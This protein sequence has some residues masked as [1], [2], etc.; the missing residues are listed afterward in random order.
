MGNEKFVKQIDLFTKTVLD[1]IEK[2]RKRLAIE[3]FKRIIMR[4]PVDTGRARGNWQAT[5]GGPA[6]RTFELTDKGGEN[7]VTK[8]ANK[9]NASKLKTHPTIYL[10]NNIPYILRLENGG[11]NGPTAKVTDDG[12]SRQAPSGMVKVTLAEFPYI[13][14]QVARG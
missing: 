10:T 13:V 14:K 5:F 11:Y 4:T 12:Y 6:T 7:T 2:F 8:M 9:V 1:E 3:M